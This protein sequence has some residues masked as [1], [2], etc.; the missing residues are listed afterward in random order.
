ML[1]VETISLIAL[2]VG[3]GV[4]IMAAKSAWPGWLGFSILIPVV[5]ILL[6]VGVSPSA[7]QLLGYRNPTLAGQAYP[8]EL[9]GAVALVLLHAVSLLAG[10]MGAWFLWDRRG[11]MKPSPRGA[12]Y[13][14]HTRNRAWKASLVVFTFGALCNAVVLGFLLNGRSL[15]QLALQR[16]SLT[17]EDAVFNPL[18][19][20]ATL[21]SGFMSVGAWGMLA[22]SAGKTLRRGISLAANLAPLLLQV[23]YGGRLGVVMSLV[24]FLLIYHHSVKRVRSREIVLLGLS[25]I[26]AISTIQFLR[27]QTDTLEEAMLGT[28]ADFLVTGAVDEAAFATRMFPQPIPFLGWGPILGSLGHLFPTITIP[29]AKNIW[30]MLVDY[31]FSGQNTSEGIGGQHYAPAAEHFILFG[32]AGVVLLG[33]AFGLLYGRLF[34]WQKRQPA[35]LFILLFTVYIYKSFVSSAM[36]GK[37]AASVGSIGFGALLPI[38]ILA[39]LTFGNRGPRIVL[40]SSVYLCALSFLLKRLL[41]SD[42]LDYS[43]SAALAFAYLASFRLISQSGPEQEVGSDRREDKAIVLEGIPDSSPLLGPTAL[44][45]QGGS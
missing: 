13:S 4:L 28:A 23:L 39:G 15:E 7:S 36:D 10:M 1:T 21:L 41:A 45:R 11:S 17:A 27:F 18:Y 33:V 34:I 20:Y 26:V 3:V 37:M 38:G 31:L 40:A 44:E 16:A 30:M 29:G 35:N 2:F 12:E 24:P 6:D 43:F 5:S 25:A 14:E 32:L 8:Q 9:H 22:F 42:I 19:N